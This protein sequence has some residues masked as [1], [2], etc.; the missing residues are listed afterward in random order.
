MG[1]DR[2][3]YVRRACPCGKGEIVINRAEPDH[4]FGAGKYTWELWLECGECQK[5]YALIEQDRKA[6]LVHREEIEQRKQKNR[7][8][9]ERERELENSEK[10]RG[11]IQQFAE[12]I[13]NEDTGKRKYRYGPYCSAFGISGRRI[14]KDL[15]VDEIVALITPSF[16]LRAIA[17]LLKNI[18]V[19]DDE[20]VNELAQNAKEYI[21]SAPYTVIG[22]PIVDLT[23]EAY[24]KALRG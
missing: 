9:Y 12:L 13:A 6:V 22:D 20:L 14:S 11:Y 17:S 16:K 18:A 21:A 15:S 10:V 23:D 8:I 19:R 2:T 3:E 1:T 7:A 5:E 4:P 24:Y